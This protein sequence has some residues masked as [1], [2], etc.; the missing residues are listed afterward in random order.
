MN[1]V[2]CLSSGEEAAE[3]SRSWKGWGH[4]TELVQIC[5]QLHLVMPHGLQ[6]RPW[7]YGCLSSN[8]RS[9]SMFTAGVGLELSSLQ[10]P[11]TVLLPQASHLRQSALVP[12]LVKGMDGMGE[13]LQE[14]ETWKP[15][16]QK[17][18]HSRPGGSGHQHCGG[19]A[20]Q[21][22]CSLHHPSMSSGPLL[23]SLPCSPGSVCSHCPFPCSGS[24]FLQT[25]NCQ[26]RASRQITTYF[27]K[28]LLEHSHTHLYTYCLWHNKGRTE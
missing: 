7:G 20:H 3:V 15:G 13:P 26:S 12:T 28:V 22:S 2:A 27:R 11:E 24:D 19:G 14:F 23:L 18:R 1:W 16:Q 8:R 5:P 4:S 17:G 21:F 6:G 10:A 9:H 25:S